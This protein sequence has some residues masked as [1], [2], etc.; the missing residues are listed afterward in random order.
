[1][2]VISVRLL[3]HTSNRILVTFGVTIGTRRKR[4]AKGKSA[5]IE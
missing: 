5:V 2:S 4:N 1:M 3:S